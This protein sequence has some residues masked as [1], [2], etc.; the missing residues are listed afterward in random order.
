MRK[1]NTR[2]YGKRHARFQD[3]ARP[4]AF[5]GLVAPT[6]CRPPSGARPIAFGGLVA[7]QE[8]PPSAVPRIAAGTPL[9]RLLGGS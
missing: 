2:D 8:Q 6:G 4:M 3:G 1:P 7:P 5:G 9:G